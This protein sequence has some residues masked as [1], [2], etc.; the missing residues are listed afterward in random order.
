MCI[1]DSTALGDDGRALAID[2]QRPTFQHQTRG[3]QRQLRLGADLIGH[4]AVKA[5]LLL[6][7]PA[8]E[9]ELDAGPLAVLLAYKDGA[10]ICL[11]YTSRC[12]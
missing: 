1:R 8:V 4:L 7:A 10:G 6:F 5:G 11:L 2:L 12:V 9:I 3:K